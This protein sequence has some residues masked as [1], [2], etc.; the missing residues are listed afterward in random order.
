M[1]AENA[2]QGRNPSCN[3]CFNDETDYNATRL[4]PPRHDSECAATFAR[5][6]PTGNVPSAVH[7]INVSIRWLN[8]LSLASAAGAGGVTRAAP[9]CR[10]QWLYF[11]HLALERHPSGARPSDAGAALSPHPRW[12]LTWRSRRLPRRRPSGA[13]VYG[14][15]AD[16]IAA[17]HGYRRTIG[18]IGAHANAATHDIAHGIAEARGIAT[19]HVV[20]GIAARKASPHPR[21]TWDRRNPCG[22]QRPWMRSPPPMSSSPP[23][24]SPQ[25]M[26]SPQP[27]APERIGST[28]ADIQ[29]GH[30]VVG[31]RA[32]MTSRTPHQGLER[33]AALQHCDIALGRPRSKGGT[34][35]PKLAPLGFGRKMSATLIFRGAEG[36]GPEPLCPSSANPAPW[37]PRVKLCLWRRSHAVDHAQSWPSSVPNIANDLCPALLSPTPAAR[38]ETFNPTPFRLQGGRRERGVSKCCFPL[39]VPEG[40]VKAWLP[41]SAANVSGMRGG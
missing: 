19:P 29:T 9:G 31:G 1:G 8:S 21:S 3:G 33:D 40:G 37:L 28:T 38:T 26:E 22:R 16:H 36:Q 11:P 7:R 18:I 2:A 23:K 6:R 24:G 10:D 4:A 12:Y 35:W 17:T 32:R 25:G 14:I 5:A 34:H 39:C 41:M 30:W 13:A 20:H 15:A 27:K